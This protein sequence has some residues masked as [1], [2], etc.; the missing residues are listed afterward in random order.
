MSTSA[1]A[2]V[3]TQHLTAQ[4]TLS[5]NQY[6]RI[7]AHLQHI[8][9]KIGVASPLELQEMYTSL[10][11]L[12]RQ[13]AEIDRSCLD[14]VM[15]DPAIAKAVAALVDRRTSIVKKVLAANREITAKAIGVQSLLAHEL[16]TLR[17][18][19][20]ALSG[21]RQPERPQGRLIN[22]MS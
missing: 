10:A 2:T 8:D 17:T 9:G 7:L 18:G 4:L 5:S 14:Q 15:A 20:S 19:L 1:E 12:Q 16:G 13:A 11:E 22:S 3:D 6:Q 21:Y